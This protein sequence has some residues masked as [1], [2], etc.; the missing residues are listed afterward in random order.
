[1]RPYEWY[2]QKKNIKVFIDNEEVGAVGI[3][4]TV[5]FDVSSGKHKVVLKNRLSNGSQPFEVD[6]SNNEDK[7]IRMSTF[8]YLWLLS[9]VFFKVCYKIKR[10]GEN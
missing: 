6:L 7:I 1:M 3:D 10:G 5:H 9:F 8:K 4:N 2:N